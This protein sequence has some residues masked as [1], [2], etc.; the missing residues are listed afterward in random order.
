VEAYL[1]FLPACLPMPH[2]SPRNQRWFARNPWFEIEVLP[3]LQEFVR[4]N[5]MD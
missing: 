3:E 4:Q 1:D 5:L 2:P